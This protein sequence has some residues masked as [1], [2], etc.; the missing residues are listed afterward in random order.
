MRSN[1]PLLLATLSPLPAVAQTVYQLPAIESVSVSNTSKYSDNRLRA[2]TGSGST[3]LLVRGL[4]K[5]DVSAIPDTATI[6]KM[7]LTLFMENQFNSPLGN[8]V[9]DLRYSSDDTWT[10][11]NAT[12]AS[13]PMGTVVCAQQSGFVHPKHE[14]TIDLQA[15]NFAAD[16]L[17]DKISLVIQNTTTTYSYVYF[18]GHTG[19]PV[20]PNAVLEVTIGSCAGS[21]LAFGTGGRDS[22][23]TLVRAVSFGCPDRGQVLSLGARLGTNVTATIFTFLGASN[24]QWGATQLPLELTFLNA[25][26]NWLNIS[27]DYLLGS[28]PNSGGIGT[29]P[30]TIP[31]TPGLAGQI[32]YSQSVVYDPLANGLGL[33]FSEGFVITIG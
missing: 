22:S 7:K 27:P 24:T 30:V 9:V 6:S 8:P 16:L 17:D 21:V 14:F 26:G 5:F 15:Y 3:P 20:G 1:L 25:P 18:F 33:V 11:A 28:A 2:Y 12:P 31:T 10:R 32:L 19:T 4:Y 29:V 23:N 13:A